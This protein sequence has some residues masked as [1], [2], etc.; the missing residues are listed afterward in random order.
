M[1]DLGKFLGEA[2]RLALLAGRELMR[3]RQ[4][5]TVH[6]ESKAQLD[7]VY[8]ELTSCRQVLVAL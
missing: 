1:P 5:A 2:Q 3:H 6:A 4:Q 7:A 8:T